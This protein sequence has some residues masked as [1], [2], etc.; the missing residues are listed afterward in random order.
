M[1]FSLVQVTERSPIGEIVAD[2]AYD[3]FSKYKYL[4]VSLVFPISVFGVGIFLTAPFPDHYL[5]VPFL[6][7]QLHSG[8]GPGF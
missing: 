6:S 2:S 5:L 8:A 4:I 3:M 1:L 7:P